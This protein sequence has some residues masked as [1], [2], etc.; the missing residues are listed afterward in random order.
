MRSATAGAREADGVA[1]R[2]WRS[3]G[4]TEWR[5]AV[6][7]LM[8]AIAW[9]TGRRKCV[10]DTSDRGMTEIRMIG[11]GEIQIVSEIRT[12]IE[13]EIE[14]G[15]ETVAVVSD[16]TRVEQANDGVEVRCGISRGIGI[17]MTTAAEM[18]AVLRDTM[19]GIEEIRTEVMIEIDLVV[20]T[21]GGDPTIEYLPEVLGLVRRTYMLA[22]TNRLLAVGC[23][24]GGISLSNEDAPKV[25]LCR[26]G[27]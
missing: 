15:T 24:R 3:G 13:T 9:S 18:T 14:S 4:N 25:V 1:L 19:I 21:D 16:A 10:V 8:I 17:G 6:T 22:V 5:T 26:Y 23:L 2:G 12:R 7:I 20:I 27:F 11:G